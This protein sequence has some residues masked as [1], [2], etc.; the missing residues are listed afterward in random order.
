MKLPAY[1]DMMKTWPEVMLKVNLFMTGVSEK[2]TAEVMKAY[3]GGDAAGK[4][5]DSAG[6]SPP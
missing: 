4:A 5:G 2:D 6:T 3:Q 1:V